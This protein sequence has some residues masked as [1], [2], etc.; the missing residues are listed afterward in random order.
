MCRTGGRRCKGSK[1]SSRATQTTRKAV[2]RARKALREAKAG[3][4]PDAI[5]DARQRL[6]DA[7]AEHAAARTRATHEDTTMRHNDQD[8]A[9]H[10]GD[11]TDEPPR[12]QLRAGGIGHIAATTVTHIDSP[13]G[14][15]NLGSGNQYTADNVTFGPGSTL[16]FGPSGVTTTPPTPRETPGTPGDLTGEPSSGGPTTNVVSHGGRITHHTTTSDQDPGDTA[17]HTGDGTAPTGN[18]SVPPRDAAITALFDMLEQHGVPGRLPVDRSDPAV[19][20]GLIPPDL[21]PGR[22]GDVTGSPRR[23][24]R[25]TTPPADPPAPPGQHQRSGSRRDADHGQRP[26]HTTTRTPHITVV[27]TNMTSGNA[28]VGSQ[29]DVMGDLGQVDGQRVADRVQR[30]IK[31]AKRATEQARTSTPGTTHNTA[32]GDDDV[33]VQIGFRIGDTH[34]HGDTD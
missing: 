21:V 12:E 24:R 11:V 3:G 4:D 29:H 5:A 19:R 8:T 16:Y 30:A 26:E 7:R 9:G 25:D 13:T 31:R 10:N 33:N 22:H 18:R 34:H 1:A 23:A 2:S 27:N 17:G 15:V 14:P 32:S 6:A 28:T 20:Y